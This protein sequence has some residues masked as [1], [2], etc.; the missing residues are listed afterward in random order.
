MAPTID[1]LND[2]IQDLTNDIR[3]L[4]V[5][6]G[7]VPAVAFPTF[8]GGYDDKTLGEF[9]DRFYL[10]GKINGWD[11]KRCCD[12]FPAALSGEAL[13][14]YKSLP[15]DVQNDWT[16][17]ADAF[18]QR[19]NRS[20]G[21]RRYL[22]L[23]ERRSQTTDESV[24]TF[25]QAIKKLAT[26]AYPKTYEYEKANGAKCKPYDDDYIRDK[27]VDHFLNGLRPQLR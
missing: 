1:Q 23:L 16:K 24:V 2:T 25:S 7:N 18:Q 22:R 11:Q 26:R 4:K 3:T 8:D 6:Q 5:C 13:V 17:L 10:Y 19:F 12:V 14:A 27:T 9:L 20:E 15:T 21:H